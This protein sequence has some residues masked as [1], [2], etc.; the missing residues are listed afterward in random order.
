MRRINK[1]DYFIGVFLATIMNSS[2]GVPAL[3]D[4][5]DNSKRIEFETDT[6]YF[7]VYI[8]YSTKA[9]ETRTTVKGKRKKKLSWNISFSDRDYQI[10]KDSFVLKDKKNL[11]CLVCTNEKLNDT[12]LAV[13]DH[14]G[15]VK[16]LGKSTKSGCRRITVTRIGNE[17]NFNLYGVGF[18]KDDYIQVAL[19]PTN[20]LGLKE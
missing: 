18:K 17:H 5:T 16:C 4:E 6:G 7:N 12:Y 13:L 10:L 15:A 14:D 9:V 3:F 11:V 1:L 8:K 20:F 2:N 19:D